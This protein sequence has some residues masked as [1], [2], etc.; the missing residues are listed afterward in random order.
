MGIGLFT[1]KGHPPSDTEI[2]AAVGPKLDLWQ[3]LLQ[4][5]RTSYRAQE[6]LKFMYGHP[7]G[8]A[9]RFRARGKLL[10]ALY[11]TDSGF[12]VQIIL[13]T[14]AIEQAQR[15]ALGPHVQGVIAQAHPYPEGRW[16]F[17]PVEAE[18]D[19]GDIEQLLP[20]RAH[21]KPPSDPRSGVGT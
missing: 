11:P 16:L 2:L 21:T 14:A 12:T 18:R 7:Y 13:S 6:D 5:I 4:F 19:A 15:L 1:D 9:L 20:L 17:I 10:T 8:W 3:R